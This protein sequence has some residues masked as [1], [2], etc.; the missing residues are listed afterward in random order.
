MIHTVS[1]EEYERYWNDLEDIYKRK[2][3][4][5]AVIIDDEDPEFITLDWKFE[6]VR[7]ERIRRITGYLTGNTNTWN[8]AKQAELEDRK[9]NDISQNLH[10]L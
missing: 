8:E 6:P 10:T 3:K 5:L 4:S 9:K 2:L 7:F 1:Q